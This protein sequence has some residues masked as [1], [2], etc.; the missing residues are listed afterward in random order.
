MNKI[1]I[2][3]F[4]S[5]GDIILTTPLIRAVRR[6]YP[7]AQIDFVVKD[8]FAALVQGNPHLTKVYIFS[9]EKDNLKSIKEDIIEEEYDWIIDIHKNFRS[10]YLRT[11]S[12]AVNITD[13]PKYLFKRTLLV[14]LRWNFYKVVEPVYKRYFKAVEPFGIEDDGLGTEIFVEPALEQYIREKLVDDGYNFSLPLV[15][16]SPGASYKN[17]RW[18]PER[19]AELIDRYQQGKRA[20][21]VMAGGKEDWDLCEEINRMA[22]THALNYAGAFDLLGAAALL[23]QADLVITNDT[24]I[25]HMAQSQKVPVTAIFGP[26]TRELGYFPF[27]GTSAVIELKLSCRPCTHNGLD[28]CPKGHFRC[29]KDISTEEVFETSQKLLN[30]EAASNN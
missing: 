17:K 27:P 22:M 8:Q 26:T 15:V 5:M 14:A 23:K 3:R 11:R 7:K 4:S 13:Y 30:F 24:G 10:L 21:V 18:L 9:K 19:F 6:K 20:F 28:H 16:I 1:L 12:G 29:M 25:M 2:I